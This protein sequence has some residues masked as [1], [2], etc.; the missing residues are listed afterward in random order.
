MPVMPKR[1]TSSANTISRISPTNAGHALVKKLV[2]AVTMVLT[3]DATALLVSGIGIGV[4]VMA[5][6]CINWSAP[7]S[8]GAVLYS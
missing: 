7:N 1:S 2:V 6:V 4:A 3:V 5:S 8:N